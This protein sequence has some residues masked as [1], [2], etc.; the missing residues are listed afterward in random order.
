MKRPSF[1]RAGHPVNLIDFPDKEWGYAAL[2]DSVA[3]N[4]INVQVGA[5]VNQ[6]DRFAFQKGKLT[7][8]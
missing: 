8:S 1:I 2:A 3:K 5:A 7:R 4:G 6:G